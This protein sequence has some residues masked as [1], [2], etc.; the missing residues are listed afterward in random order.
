[1][2]T[3]N[4]FL[5]TERIGK[6][7]KQYAVPCIVSLLVGALYNIVD[8]I[9]IAN[10][11]YLGSYGNAANTVVF[12]LTVVA[13]AIAVMIGD[14]CCAYVSICLGRQEVGTAKRSVGN[15]VVMAVS[16]GVVLAALYL[17]FAAPIISVFGGTV[18]AETFRH[19]SEYFFF[20]TLGIPFYMFGQAMNPI[21]RADGNPRFA[22]LSTLAGAAVNIVLD[23]IFIF[24]CRW[25][26]MGAAVATVIGQVLTAVLSVWYLAHMKIIRPQKGDY[27]LGGQVCGR[28]LALGITSFL[29]Q[30]SLV[31]A[32]AAINNML[33]KYGALDPIFGQ[34]QYAQ[35]PMAV[36]GIVM[37]FF[38]IVI[39]IVVGMAAGCIPIVGFNMGAGKFSRV[40]ELFTRLLL[41]EAAV[42]AVALVLV[43]FFPRQLI[44]IFGAANES[45]YYTDF[46]IRAFRVYLCMMIFACINKACFIFLQAMGKAVESTVLSMIREVV[47]GVGFALLLPVWFGLDGVLYSMPVSDVLTFLVAAVLIVRTYRELN[48]KDTL[49]MPD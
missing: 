18:N 49:P 9:F 25:G 5:G 48:R 16:S 17:A 37:K 11:S 12:P 42:G 41:A 43:E 7:M 47:F 13:L 19:S 30:I 35:I 22:M 40:R 32:M 3:S 44:G 46:A 38:Q 27:R 20:I 31:A 24:I 33:R 10:A 1:M 6:L 14:G 21:I 2:E 26:M 23:P 45:S 36:V 34:E 4:Q 15:A 28:T 29:S 8:Q 39:S